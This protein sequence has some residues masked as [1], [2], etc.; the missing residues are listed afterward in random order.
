[1]NN[2]ILKNQKGQTL[3]P[4]LGVTLALSLI[5]AG[6]G[7][8]IMKEKKEYII[9]NQRDDLSY[10]IKAS[11]KTSLNKFLVDMTSNFN[12][13]IN[14]WSGDGGTSNQ[15]MTD[16]VAAT[17]GDGLA[18]KSLFQLSSNGNQISTG[19]YNVSNGQKVMIF[20]V[21]YDDK[22]NNNV[23]DSNEIGTTF[24]S[25]DFNSE[26]K[27]RVY[28]YS[29]FIT[30]YA[31]IG[32]SFTTSKMRKKLT[33]T[34]I[35]S[36]S[37]A[38]RNLAEYALLMNESSGA[39]FG[40]TDTIM[41]PVHTN[42]RFFLYGTPQSGS[43]LSKASQVGKTIHWHTGSAEADSADLT[44][45][46]NKEV[47]VL[48]PKYT[49]SGVDKVKPNFA[50]GLTV[51]A[52]R[53]ELPQNAKNLERIA[54]G[55]PLSEISNATSLTVA[56][57]ANELGVTTSGSPPNIPKGIYLPKT[58]TTLK[59]G[60]YING[61]VE[62]IV[63][64]VENGKQVYDIKQ[65][66]GGNKRKRITIDKVTNT[67]KF[68]DLNYSTGSVTTTND[69]QGVPRGSFHVEGNINS[70][71]GKARPAA[72]INDPTSAEPAIQSDNELNL[73]AK[74]NIY[75]SRDIKYQSDPR[76]NPDAKNILGFLSGEGKVI[77]KDPAPKDINVH[78]IVLAGSTSGGGSFAVQN[79]NTRPRNGS[80]HL[81]GGTLIN[82]LSATETFAGNVGYGTDFVY[83]ERTSHGQSPP[84]FPSGPVSQANPDIYVTSADDQQI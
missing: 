61:D 17:L 20:S 47:N 29:F 11:E 69:Y 22:N 73:S 16:N 51:N 1:M 10:A 77:I 53:I 34:G 36:L 24:I 37:A 72:T 26:L 54:I 52:S 62:D 12:V 76:T 2:K 67:T 63:M 59:G 3:I 15:I 43:F 31:Y 40:N 9:K 13:K 65:T 46:Q 45:G 5:I 60:I 82:E 71:G 68:E 8:S 42:E 55:R 50:A 38:P 70:V 80:I 27:K 57:K 25:Q 58:G 84:Y 35:I 49:V 56:E 75:I 6:I 39:Y 7:L 44:G 64:Y 19:S 23:K 14:Q 21:P 18:G 48:N 66:Q 83:D 30:S 4:A 81:L 41:G 32:N 79:F 33:S 78:G 28:K 74:G